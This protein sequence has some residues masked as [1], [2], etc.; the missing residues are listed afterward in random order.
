[1]TVVE[2]VRSSRMFNQPSRQVTL[3][4]S[5]YTMVVSQGE[6]T[7]TIAGIDRIMGFGFNWAPPSV[8]VDT[9]GPDATVAMIEATEKI[10]ADSRPGERALMT[11]A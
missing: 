5:G 4:Q 8:L 2:M 10:L 6:V 3:N 7:Q 9:L 11:A 1:M